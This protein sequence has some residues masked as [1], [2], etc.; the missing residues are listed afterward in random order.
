MWRHSIA[1][2]AE[3]PAWLWCPR[4]GTGS[5][6]LPTGVSESRGFLAA[7]KTG[8]GGHIV[9]IMKMPGTIRVGSTWDRDVRGFD[10]ARSP[11]AD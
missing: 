6:A 5:E 11:F 1:T 9:V 7:D 2:E 8:G 4:R 10:P 3:E